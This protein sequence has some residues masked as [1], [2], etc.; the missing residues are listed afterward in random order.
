MNE[1]SRLFYLSRFYVLAGQWPKQ[2]DELV[3]V[4][5]DVERWCTG[6][7]QSAAAGKV[8]FLMERFTCDVGVPNEAVADAMDTVFQVLHKESKRL[9]HSLW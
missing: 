7:G 2:A 9:I 8:R 4:L 6:A 5:P 1:W 3:S